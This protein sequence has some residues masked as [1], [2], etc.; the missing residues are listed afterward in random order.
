MRLRSEV[1]EAGNL[2]ERYTNHINTVAEAALRNT[3]LLK[4]GAFRNQRGIEAKGKASCHSKFL[5][6]EYKCRLCVCVS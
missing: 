4:V 2:T 3:H 6:Y 5:S 1:E